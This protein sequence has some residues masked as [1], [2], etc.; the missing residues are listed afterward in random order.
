MESTILSCSSCGTTAEDQPRVYPEWVDGNDN[1]AIFSRE[2]YM[3]ARGILT[4]DEVETAK[5]Q[6]SGVV[7]QWFEKYDATGEEGDDWEEVA[8]R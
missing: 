6:I 8:N 5:L 1:V 2:G 3:I 7:K 4:I